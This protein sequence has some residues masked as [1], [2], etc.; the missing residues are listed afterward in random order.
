[1]GHFRPFSVWFVAL[2]AAFVIGLAPPGASAQGTEGGGGGGNA[3]QTNSYTLSQDTY[4]QVQRIEKMMGNDKYDQALSLAHSLMPRARRESKYANA[5]VDQLIAQ[6]Y[7]LQ[8]DYQKA[9]PYLEEIVKLDALQPE[10][11]E[12]VIYQLANIY[13]VQKQ[14]DQSI[15]LYK[16]VLAQ[17]EKQKK[18]PNPQL[19]YQ[20]GL[21]YSL[22]GD[23]RQ[24]Y[25]FI[26]EAISKA[27]KPH[28][29]W[30]QNWFI[31]AYKMK[32]YSKAK[33]I[34]KTLVADWPND[35]EFWSY[36]AN[37]Y[38]LLNQDSNAAATYALMR[39]RGMLKTK[40]QYFQ[41]ANLYLEAK[42]PYKAAMLLQEGMDKG[43]VPKTSDN[44]E[45]LAN[46]FMQSREWDKA[47]DI[48]GKEAQLAPSG[49][50]Y[51]RQASIYLNQQDYA[52]SEQAAQN[53][54]NKGGM[55]SDDE[56]QA[57]MILG[58]AAYAQK[59]WDA[60]L[61]AF[62]QAENFKSEA[63]NAKNWVQYVLT[64]RN[65]GNSGGGGH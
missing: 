25:N 46:A 55:K 58:Q 42:A 39:D 17:K 13:L 16:E 15:A 24:A 54:L 49:S 33:D 10:S 22:K 6:V 36:L 64:T 27:D 19:Y 35:K 12:S 9:E 65:G 30:Y 21:A 61:H 5:L 56:A 2:A 14:Y 11:Q 31:V 8:K 26:E 51:L 43:I 4:D 48:L 38:L 47:L 60:A 3:S 40:D 45:T 62:H 28:Q 23:Y 63:S 52:K 37:T 34:A 57:W 59:N 18:I 1:M 29:D 7:L 41:L 32:D 53:A 44:Y 50:V 20:L